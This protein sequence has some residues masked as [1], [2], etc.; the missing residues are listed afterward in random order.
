MKAVPRHLL[1]LGGGRWGSNWRRLCSVSAAR[2][3]WPRGLGISCRENRP[4]SA[5]RSR[6]RSN[7]TASTCARV[8]ATSARREGSEFVLGFADGSERRGDQ[9]LVATGRRP[10]VEGIGLETVGIKVD[11]HGI[12]V[13]SQLPAGERLWAIGDVNGVWPL[14]HVGEYQGDIVAANI[15]GQAREANYEAVPAC[16]L[17]GPAGRVGGLGG[18][19]RLQR[20]GQPDRGAENGDVLVARLRGLE[21]FPHPVGRRPEA[22]RRLRPGPEAGE[23]LQQA[24]LAIRARVPVEVMRDTIPALPDV[25]RYLQC[26]PESVAQRDDGGRPAGGPEIIR[27]RTVPAAKR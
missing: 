3:W 16:R 7:G 18:R 19:G 8:T 9:L 24:T 21:R 20:D 13:D 14:T 15:L 23:W 11:S 10:R 17:Y 12:A 6:R 5:Q 25:L 1:V 2:W 4:R 26:R 27:I 22:D